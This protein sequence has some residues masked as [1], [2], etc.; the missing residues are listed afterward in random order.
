MSAAPW[1]K[2]WWNWY[3]S[4]SH[5]GLSGVAL[6]LGPALM[7]ICKDASQR[8]RD[9]HCDASGDASCDSVPVVDKAGKP[10]TAAKLANV[11]RFSSE[12]VDLAL[13][14]LV[15]CETLCVSAD[16][17]YTFPNYAKYQEAPSAARTRRY[18]GKEERHSDAAGDAFGDGVG[19]D[20]RLEER[21]KR[22]EREEREEERATTPPRS[23]DLA[24]LPGSVVAP[25]ALVSRLLEPLPLPVAGAAMAAN[26][27]DLRQG[28]SGPPTGVQERRRP[29]TPRDATKSALRAATA[30]VCGEFGH[31][32]APTASDKHWSHGTAK[33]AGL[34]KS[35]AELPLAAER[36]ARCA[37]D[38]LRSG[39]SSSYGYALQDCVLGAAERHSTQPPRNGR[40][41]MAPATTHEDFADALPLEEQLK[42]F[43][44][45]T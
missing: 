42:K 4:R 14:E 35:G 25:L 11:V 24:P 7:L 29:A 41:Q 39:K 40:M 26:D 3:A 2:I 20:K 1:A 5:L 37:L 6:A 22:E 23:S 13:Q 45:A 43:G 38:R 15:E 17:V 30:L 16:G 31:E 32:V 28:D 44:E 33:V 19:D 12:Q 34:V 21:G 8:H 18:R 27:R 9:R 36:V 10:F